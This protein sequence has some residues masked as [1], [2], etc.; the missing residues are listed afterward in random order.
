MWSYSEEND[1]NGAISKE[2][3]D[4]ATKD[5]TLCAEDTIPMFFSRNVPLFKKFDAWFVDY[6]FTPCII[7]VLHCH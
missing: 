4:L 2:S 7:Q 6:N 1:K 5:F 3:I